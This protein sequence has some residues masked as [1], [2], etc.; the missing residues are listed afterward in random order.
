MADWTDVGCSVVLNCDLSDWN[1][2]AFHLVPDR[3]SNR[4]SF[5]CACHAV[6]GHVRGTK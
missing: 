5:D 6:V 1:R 2:E 4:S 3:I